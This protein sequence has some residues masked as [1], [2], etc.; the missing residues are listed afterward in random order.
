M[1]VSSR[2]ILHVGDLAV[3]VEGARA[4]GFSVVLLA[5]SGESTA[6]GV[7]V[8]RNLGEVLSHVQSTPG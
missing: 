8:I 5:R 7:P 4:A 3:D 1:G 2:E 6:G